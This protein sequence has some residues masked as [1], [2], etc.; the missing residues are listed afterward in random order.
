HGHFLPGLI[1]RSPRE[2]RSGLL[3]GS[4]L[5]LLSLPEASPCRSRIHNRIH[6]LP[7]LRSSNRAE[8]IRS[9]LRIAL[10]TS[11]TL[12]RNSTS[13]YP[14]LRK[15]PPVSRPSR[16]RPYHDQ[17][18]PIHPGKPESSPPHAWCHGSQFPGEPWS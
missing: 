8:R 1:L 9:E 16:A 17:S 15:L 10:P 5:L 14:D 3:H 6:R 13:R 11:N 2:P 7:A 18:L 12:L 4:L